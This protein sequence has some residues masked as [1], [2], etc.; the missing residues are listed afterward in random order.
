[1]RK[2]LIVATVLEK[3]IIKFHLD[4][5]N[6]LVDRGYQVDICSNNDTN[7]DITKIEGMNKYININFSKNLFSILN[8][9]HFY[10]IN[11]IYRDYD[12]IHLHTPIASAYFRFVSLFNNTGTKLIYTVHGF[13]FHSKT[14]KIL[15]YIIFKIEE[16]LS[17]RL[18]AMITI[19]EYDYNQSKLMKGNFKRYIINSNGINFEAFEK[20]EINNNDLNNFN[21]KVLIS[22][23]EL[24][25]NKNHL[26]VLKA[27]SKI[28]N[29]EFKYF[30]LGSGKLH[31]KYIKIINKF[32]LGDKVE[33]LGY[34]REK[35]KLFE[36][37][38]SADIFIH[39]SFREGVPISVLEAIY[40]NCELILSDVRGNNDIVKNFK[41]TLFNPKDYLTLN[42]IID[43][44]LQENKK[45]KNDLISIRNKLNNI[46]SIKNINDF[47][48]KIYEDL[49]AHYDIS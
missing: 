42:K 31:K 41:A 15:R 20:I 9:K 13:H 19:N 43:T 40:F 29:S 48:I 34:I 18:Y 23:G 1:M 5:I 32:Q 37:L 25:K 28:K 2:V 12:V 7:F 16:I 30:I 8:F 33:M 27:L 38:N 22:V 44:K 35:K 11:K 39:P 4:F 21:K 10:Q 49:E 46:Y 45:N 17:K 36:Y 3:H 14:S 24:N 26:V 6:V 47:L